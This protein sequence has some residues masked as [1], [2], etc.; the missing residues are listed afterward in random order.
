[1]VWIPILGL[2]AGLVLGTI[3]TFL[4]PVIYAKYLSIAVLAAL[5]SILGG[6]RAVLNRNFDRSILLSGFFTNA[7]L[8]AGLAYL[9]DRLGVDLYLAAV[10]AFG[11]RLF[12]NLGGIRRALLYQRRKKKIEKKENKAA[13]NDAAAAEAAIKAAAV[14]EQKKIAANNKKISTATETKGKKTGKPK[15]EVMHHKRNNAER[16]KKS[17]PY[18]PPLQITVINFPQEDENKENEDE[19]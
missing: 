4:V 17:D 15:A 18:M 10:F 11:I 12:N 6:V 13:K 5:D 3:S 2:A 8:A 1:M 14:E 9:G 19:K 7:I 16:D